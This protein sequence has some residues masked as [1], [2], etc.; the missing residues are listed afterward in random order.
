MKQSTRSF[1]EKAQRAVITAERL[2]DIGDSEFS[3]GRAY[4]AMFYA[5]QSLLDHLGL[6]FRKHSGVHIALGLHLVKPGILD[7]RF[8]H[9]LIAAFNKRIIGDYGIDEF[10]TAEEVREMLDLA[11]EFIVEAMRI[12]N[13]TDP[14]E[15]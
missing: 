5:A 1:L 14:L 11:N 15:P 10:I 8:H 13:E 4:Y 2:L 6:R 9:G 12:I 3:S 7:A